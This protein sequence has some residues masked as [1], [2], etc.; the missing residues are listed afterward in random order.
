MPLKDYKGKKVILWPQYFDSSLSHK[1][2]RKLPKDECVPKPTQR[3]LLEAARALGLNPEPLEGRY[4]R[5]WW[6][7]EGPIL[8]D[9]IASKREIMRMVARELR[10]MRF[11]E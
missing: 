4:P 6:N 1:K 9:K 5:E 8:V 3:E 10:K 11:G 7:K 2:G